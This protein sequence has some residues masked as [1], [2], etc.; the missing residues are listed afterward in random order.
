MERPIASSSAAFR[1]YY[2]YNPYSAVVVMRV[3]EIFRVAYNYH[4]TGQKGS[5]PAQRLGLIDRACSLDELL[6]AA[7]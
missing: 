6:G 2:G 7:A 5:T 4:L 1:N 3:L